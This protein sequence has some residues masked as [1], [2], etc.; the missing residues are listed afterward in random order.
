MGDSVMAFWGAPLAE[1]DHVR[2]ACRTALAVRR[3]ISLD[4]DHRARRGEAPV[5]LRIGVHTGLAIVG[6]IGAPGRINYTLVGDTVNI[7]QRLQELGKELGRGSTV[8]ILVSA[9]VAAVLGDRYPMSSQGAQEIRGR[10]GE[11][12]VFRLE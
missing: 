1:E 8:E 9:D 12:E 10:H 3:A 6:N 11:L 2:R 4:N 5:R 7:A